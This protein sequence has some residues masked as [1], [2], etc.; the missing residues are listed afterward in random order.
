MNSI[1]ALPA[2]MNFIDHGAGGPASS[3]QMA[4]GA[5]PL[6]A[7]DEV[8]IKVV[9]AGINRPDVSQRSGSYPPPD[10]KSTV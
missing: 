7:D 3:M 8:L 6:L 9:A 5:L 10:R 1:T 2:T 4:I